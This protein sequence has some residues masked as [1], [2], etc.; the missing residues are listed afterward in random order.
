VF[1]LYLNDLE[2]YVEGGRL[3]IYNSKVEQEKY[4]PRPGDDN[5][6][7]VNEFKPKAGKLV[8]FLNTSNSYHSVE[9]MTNTE[10]GR[11]FLY[12]AYTLSSGFGSLAKI[13]S[14]GKL[15]TEYNLY[16]E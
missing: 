1:L 7:V 11:H 5:V 6:Y 8:M 3:K 9:K 16:R 10:Y 2:D 12:G 14:S 15:P 13:K 4:A